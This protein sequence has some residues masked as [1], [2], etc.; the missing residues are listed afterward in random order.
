MIHPSDH[1]DPEADDDA[2]RGPSKSSLKREMHALQDI[3]TQLVALSA[4]RLAK[5]PLPDT[6]RDAVREA[7]RISAHGARR[8]QLQYIGRLMR[9]VDPAPI[10]AQLDAFNGVSKAEVA[11][12][13]RLERLRN[14]FLEDEKR[15]GDIASQW[16]SADLQHL[17]VLRRNARKEREQGKPP[18]AY[19]EL[20]RMLRD[21]DAGEKGGTGEESAIENEDREHRDT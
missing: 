6:L 5:V 4:E 8:R 3:G 14:D 9:G 18:R 15:I 7:Q 11:R 20:F 1:H 21:L 12:Q 2:T 13:H 19:R 16:P 10:Q 17:R